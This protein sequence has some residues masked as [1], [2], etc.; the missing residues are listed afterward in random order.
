MTYEQ[1]I[2]AI[3]ALYSNTGRSRADTK[4]DLEA[5]VEECEILIDTL[6]D[7]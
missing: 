7:E 1:V 4:S 3:K 6:D 5:I 2:E